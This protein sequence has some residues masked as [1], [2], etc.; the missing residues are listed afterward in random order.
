MN[1]LSQAPHF[2][3]ALSSQDT[4]GLLA[5][6]AYERWRATL[7]GNP[8]PVVRDMYERITNP[9]PGDLVLEVT[10]RGRD[11][12]P[13][14]ALG[15]LLFVAGRKPRSEDEWHEAKAA[16]WWKMERAKFGG[17]YWYVDPIDGVSQRT[18]WA[19]CDFI[20]ASSVLP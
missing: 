15:R 16:G 2:P 20:V 13:G 10:T 1:A 17:P 3:E 14:P 19:N 12:W 4:A 5:E 18:A 6:V 8:A 9:Q 11:G 7:V